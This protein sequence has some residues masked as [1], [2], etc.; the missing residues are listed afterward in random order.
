MVKLRSLPVFV[1]LV[2]HGEVD[3]PRALSYGRL[4]GFRLSEVGRAQARVTADYLHAFGG[5]LRQVVTSPLERAQETAEILSARLGLP[6]ASIDD[7]L[8]E[9]GSWRDGLP[10]ALSP[11]AYAR[12]YFNF[13]ERKKVEAPAAI[14][15]RMKG[16]IDD[17]IATLDEDGTAIALVSHQTPIWWARV[18][19]ERGVDAFA[20]AYFDNVT[21][22]I[23][24]RSPCDL[25]SVTTLAITQKSEGAKPSFRYFAP[26]S[27]GG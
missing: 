7:R 15:K 18:A 17:A 9:A 2:R 16:A 11:L 8:I 26:S 20:R 1:H 21:P 3:N 19:V 14:A 27:S 13:G 24:V 12:R 23:Y 6:A 25:A 4:P 10:R 5:Q 22:W